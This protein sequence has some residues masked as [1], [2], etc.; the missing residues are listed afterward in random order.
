MSRLIIIILLLFSTGLLAVVQYNIIPMPREVESRDGVFNV[1]AG[2]V[3]FGPEKLLSG[4]LE[5]EAAQVKEL[6]GNL[7]PGGNSDCSV[8]IG[9]SGTNKQF[10]GICREYR[11][12]DD[13]RIG[14]QGY[15]L[16]IE[17][18]TIIISANTSTG[19]F[20]G[21][22]TL[23]QIVHSSTS[24]PC[25]KIIDWPQYSYRGMMDDISRG[26]V[27]T[28][29]FMKFQ[30]R[31][32]AQLKIN[33]LTYYIEHIVETNSHGDFAPDEAS[34]SIDQWRE[35]SKYAR[36]HHIELVGG[37]QSFSHGEKV[38]A[39]PDYQHLAATYRMY[40][41]LLSETY[42]F[43]NNVYSEMIP[44]FESEFFAL[45]CDETWDIGAGV[46]KEKVDKIGKEQ[47]YVDHVLK[48]DNIVKK[49]NKRSIIWADIALEYP[50]ILDM[51]PKD[52][53][54]DTWTYSKMDSYREYIEP[55]HEQGFDI[56][57]SPGVLN[58]NRLMP[59][60]LLA[61]DNIHGFITEG[62][63]YNAMA[64][65]LTVWD[66]GGMA[67]FSRDWYGVAYSAE[68]SWNINGE[69]KQP[70]DE[71]FN[72]V[73]YGSANT[74][75]TDAIQILENKLDKVMKIFQRRD[76]SFYNGYLAAREVVDN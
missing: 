28:M 27:P 48:L 23:K 30:I 67:L 25:M 7:K 43:F 2:P 60:L 34:I 55:L 53:V 16:L 65:L 71:R 61:C 11:L 58:S 39:H 36:L 45:N 22:Q 1:S 44:A 17:P 5:F 66:D 37:F 26:P 63:D 13:K 9:I 41:P 54:L 35:L 15:I 29:D 57:I 33:L 21:I 10:D 56:I 18:E 52:M 12:K 73:V 50:E 42:E 19:V 49:F 20:Y 75:F 47:F 64:T 8:W 3:K 32:C 74:A 38:L 68:K 40:N 76:A 72:R 24:I 69:E 70:F 59:D 6:F 4:Q 14:D 31:R 62:A 46:T 51:L